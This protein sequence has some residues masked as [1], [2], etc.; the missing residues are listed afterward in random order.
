MTDTSVTE[1][2]DAER[3]VELEKELRAAKA[4]AAAL[5]PTVDIRDRLFESPEQV[6]KHFTVTKL[7]KMVQDQNAAEN[8][9][10]SRQGYDKIVLD[11]AS[12]DEL[13]DQLAEQF[14]NDRLNAAPEEGW[15]LRTIKMVN[16]GTGNLIQ[17]PYEGQFNNVAGS[18]R[19]GIVLYETKGYKR[20]DPMLC[21]AGDCF[22]PAAEK[23][24]KW[25]FSGYCSE[26]HYKRTEVGK[27]IELPPV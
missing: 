2:T 18:L 26:D 6:K 4:E 22:N 11:K 19:D 10:R 5:S 24:G 3:I 1:R 21:P 13:I 27:T 17:I 14:V 16:I 23:G 12:V 9:I 20:T 25:V 7:R 8:R 15:L